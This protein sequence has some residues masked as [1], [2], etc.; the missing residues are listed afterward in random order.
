MFIQRKSTL[1]DRK[2]IHFETAVV[3]WVFDEMRWL[4]MKMWVWVVGKED[5]EIVRYREE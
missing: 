1:Q 4:E 3:V 5:E 2:V